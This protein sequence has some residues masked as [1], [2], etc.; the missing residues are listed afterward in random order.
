MRSETG[1][2]KKDGGKVSPQTAMQGVGNQDRKGAMLLSEVQSD[3]EVY[4][5]SST[6]R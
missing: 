2:L 1:I 6:Y 3:S 5:P 4:D